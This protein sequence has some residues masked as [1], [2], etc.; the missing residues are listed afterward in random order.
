M[1]GQCIS[2]AQ[3]AH[4]G[5]ARG[6]L[7]ARPRQPAQTGPFGGVLHPSVHCSQPVCGCKR[8]G[9]VDP[10]QVFAVAEVASDDLA[11]SVASRAL[12]GAVDTR[13]AGESRQRPGTAGAFLRGWVALAREGPA[14][15]RARRPGFKIGRRSAGKTRRPEGLTPKDQRAPTV[16]SVGRPLVCVGPLPRDPVPRAADRSFSMTTRYDLNRL[17]GRA[18]R[19]PTP[20]RSLAPLG[21]GLSKKKG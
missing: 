5:N 12:A 14:A 1:S 2:Q 18:H 19:A 17:A 11:E 6:A 20:I 21:S 7:Q 16:A 8:A 15:P 3:P 9:R 4:S 10:T 13:E